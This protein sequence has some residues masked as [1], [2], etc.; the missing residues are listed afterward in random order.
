MLSRSLPVN[1]FLPMCPSS[2]SAST[3][4]SP[5]MCLHWSQKRHILCNNKTFSLTLSPGKKII[6]VF[7]SFHKYATDLFNSMKPPLILS[8]LII[9]VFLQSQQRCLGEQEMFSLH[10]SNPNDKS[11]VPG[12]LHFIIIQNAAISLGFYVSIDK[13]DYSL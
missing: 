10:S 3:L 4:I 11:R 2:S 13:V 8:T 1:I 5:P 9:P 12:N 6:I 7:Y